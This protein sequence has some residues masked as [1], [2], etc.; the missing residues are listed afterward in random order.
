MERRSAA[1][2]LLLLLGAIFLVNGL[3]MLAA[4]GP[5]F[6]RIA[7]DTGAFNPHLVRDV[8]AAYATSGIAAIWAARA[9]H[10]RA[11]LATTAALFQGMH[12]AIHV[13]DVFAGL[14]APSHLLE[15]FPGVYLPTLVLIG[16]ALHSLRHSPARA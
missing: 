10:W 6:A 14:L 5:W 12:G 9:P 13:F 16:I 8:G 3:I 15:D 11:P 4:P 1:Y 7:A 2:W